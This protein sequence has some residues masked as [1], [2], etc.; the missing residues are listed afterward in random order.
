[1]V[2][3]RS[4][5]TSPTLGTSGN[6]LKISKAVAVAAHAY[7]RGARRRFVMTITMEIARGEVFSF[8]LL[9]RP[10]TV[11]WNIAISSCSVKQLKN[12]RLRK[13]LSRLNNWFNGLF[14]F[15]LPFVPKGVRDANA[16]METG[17]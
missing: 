17:F 7:S 14:V 3:A 8:V 12:L 5:S 4:K 16:R 13:Q 15:V 1:L 2:K 6:G 9:G 10:S 11:S